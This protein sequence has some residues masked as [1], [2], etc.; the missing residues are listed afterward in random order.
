MYDGTQP[1]RRAPS[2]EPRFH[3]AGWL[4]FVVSAVLFIASSWEAGDMLGLAGGALFLI[5]CFVFLWPLLARPR[6]R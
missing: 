2:G 4:L 5:A 6:G 1:D 3:V